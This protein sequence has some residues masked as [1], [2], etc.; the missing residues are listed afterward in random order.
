MRNQTVK[1]LL[2]LSCL[3]FTSIS[4]I[5][6]F[7]IPDASS[8][9]TGRFLCE[10]KYKPLIEFEKGFYTEVP[11]DY[12]DPKKGTTPVY[13]S[14]W[15]DYHPELETLLYFTGGPGQ[16]SHWP[17]Q[18]D[19]GVNVLVMDQ[20]GI[21]CSRPNSV[22]T[23]LSP[24]FYSSENVA[25]DAQEILKKL[26]IQKVTVYGISYGTIP[27]TIFTSLFPQLSRALILEGTV[28]SGNSQLWEGAH[29]RKLLQ[30]MLDT[31][32]AD[33]TDL[34]K[35]VSVENSIPAIWFS[36]M[37]HN[38]L[39]SNGGL[40]ELKQNLLKL[41]DSQTY[42]NLVAETKASFEPQT[43]EPHPLFLTNDIPYYMISCQE[44][45]LNLP[46]V[47]TADALVDGKH[48]QPV[49]D[50]DSPIR[51][52]N[53]KAVAQ[54]SYDA[55][56]YP[57]SIPVT[58]FQGT[59]DS[60]TPAPLAFQHYKLVPQTSA[61][62]LILKKGGHNPNLQILNLGNEIQKEIFQQ[63]FQGLLIHETL[64]EKFNATSDLKWVMTSKKK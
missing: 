43:F 45:G 8:Y 12:Q 11:V 30:K 64:L 31:L 17:F 60:A 58:Y 40:D 49:N 9:E 39:L 27:A 18:F 5:A 15:G 52:Q 50:L 29:R 13:A 28:L 33:I 53:L 54:K 1:S 47:S 24:S 22:E 62:L 20:R 48:L 26:K 59:D 7:Q 3:L 23:Y 34:L 35:K 42:Q 37:S 46:S 41:R 36:Q 63:A 16:T 32:P 10:N 51:G 38:K 2:I 6:S 61:Q 25:R 14:F 44:L 57:V 21:G 4:S 55:Q 19:P 56:K